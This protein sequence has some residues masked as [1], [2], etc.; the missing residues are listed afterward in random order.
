M[1]ALALAL[2]ACL[3]VS[4]YLWLLRRQELAYQRLPHP[5]GRRASL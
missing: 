5:R 2:T 4:F 1:L 3:L